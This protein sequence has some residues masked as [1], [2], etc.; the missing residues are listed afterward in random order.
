M[1]VPDSPFRDRQPISTSRALEALHHGELEVVGR[2]QWSSNAT[3]LI[4]VR[5]SDLVVQG[6]YKPARGERPLWDFPEGLFYREVAS[7]E[8]SDFL[9]WDIVP[10][11]IV[12]EGPLGNGS[13]QLFIPCDL[14][15]HYFDIVKDPLHH[16]CLMKICVFDF[17]ANSTDRKGG[18]C[19]L[20]PH[21]NVWAIDNGLTFH[22][23]F[24]LRTVI[25]D[26][27]GEQIP[28]A[29]LTDLEILSTSPIPENIAS[30]LNPT[31]Q[32]AFLQRVRQLLEVQK[33]PVDTSGTRYPWPVI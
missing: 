18:H 10:P 22:N 24:K 15:I 16:Q 29:I 25:W 20:D 9:E 28:E 33:F 8:L 31:E 7:F 5:H 1:D 2:M 6:I 11:T 30:Y 26:W 17:I 19:L 3:F 14:G 23:E 32:E 4:D 12:R 27:A 21:G 13:I